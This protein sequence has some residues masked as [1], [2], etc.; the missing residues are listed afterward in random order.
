MSNLILEL[1]SSTIHSKDESPKKEKTSKFFRLIC[2]C[3]LLTSFTFLVS[4]CMVRGGGYGYGYHDHRGDR[5]GVVVEHHDYNN[6]HDFR[7]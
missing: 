1:Q 2:V 5:Q 7:D 4:S 6:H 3:F